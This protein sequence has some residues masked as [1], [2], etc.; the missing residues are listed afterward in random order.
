MTG[1]HEVRG[2]IPLGSTNHFNELKQMKQNDAVLPVF[3]LNLFGPQ[4]KR[5]SSMNPLPNGLRP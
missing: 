2:S 1:S 5:F 3:S 4:L